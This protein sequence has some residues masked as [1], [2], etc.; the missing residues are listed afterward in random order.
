MVGIKTCVIIGVLSV[1]TFDGLH[2]FNPFEL[3]VGEEEGV[4]LKAD[5]K[6]NG[7]MYP[8]IF[9]LGFFMDSC[10][11]GFTGYSYKTKYSKIMVTSQHDE[12]RFQLQLTYYDVIGLEH[13]IDSPDF[14]THTI[15]AYPIDLGN[16]KIALQCENEKYLDAGY[17][18]IDLSCN[19][20]QQD[21]CTQIGKYVL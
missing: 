5:W 17:V 21:P 10:E 20:L 2:T 1:M 15:T 3:Y 19:F 9:S 16:S 8:A 13:G 4:A 12:N 14:R 6:G 7:N 18:E 11:F